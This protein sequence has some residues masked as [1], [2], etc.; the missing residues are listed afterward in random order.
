[1]VEEVENEVK[2]KPLEELSE[3]AIDLTRKNLLGVKADSPPTVGRLMTE[4]K[5]ATWS[6]NL[7]RNA[8][9]I[10]EKAASKLF[11]GQT[12]IPKETGYLRRVFNLNFKVGT[13]LKDMAMDQFYSVKNT[14]VNA[15]Q[16]RVNYT[17]MALNKQLTPVWN[18]IGSLPVVPP[19]VYRMLRGETVEPTSSSSSSKN[20]ETKGKHKETKMTT[21]T[22]PTNVN[23]EVTVDTAAAAQKSSTT[24]TTGHTDSSAHTYVEA[25]KHGGANTIGNTNAQGLGE[26]GAAGVGMTTTGDETKKKHQKM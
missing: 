19:F 13:G 6:G 24:T 4:I 21:Q 8:L 16:S 14:T 20:R 9:S 7:F 10:S 12:E 26:K 23:V 3:Q 18:Y 11:G 17:K 5:D 22:K 25:A 15:V 2:G 1:V